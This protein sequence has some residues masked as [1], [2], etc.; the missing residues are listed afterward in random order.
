MTD[1]PATDDRATDNWAAN[2]LPT[3]GPG[4]P[5]A[6]PEWARLQRDLLSAA[7][8]AAVTFVDRYTR[9]DGTLP[10]RESWIG[11]DGSDDPYEAFQG[12]PMLYLLGGSERLLEIAHREWAAV[13]E[14]WTAYGQIYREYDGHYDWMHHG[15]ADNLLRLLGM[16]DP[17]NAEHRERVARFAGFYT[18]EDPLAPNYDPSKRLIRSPLTGSRGPRFTVTGEDWETHREVLDAYPPPFEDI[19]GVDGPTCQWTDDAIFAEILERM[20]ARMTHGDV[21][22]NLTA[23]SLLS[24]AYLLTGEDKYRQWVLGYHDAWQERTRRNNGLI[25]D[26]VG[27]TDRIG[28]NLDG[29]WWGGYYGWRWPHG[30]AQLLEAVSVASCNAALLSGDTG[31]LDL[32]RAQLDHL[33]DLGH[34]EDGGWVVPHRHVDAG[35]T[36]YRRPDPKI[37]VMCWSLTHDDADSERVRRLSDSQTWGTPT[38][39]RTKANGAGNSEHWFAYVNGA[40]PDYPTQ[41][42]RIN[43]EQLVRRLEEIRDDNGNPADWDIH[44]WQNMSPL[45]LEGL[46]QLTL[47]APMHLYHGGL[48]H[49]AVRYFDAVAKRPGLPPG[50]AA[51]VERVTSS[52]TSLQLVNCSDTGAREV[53]VQAGGF[54]EHRVEHVTDL[55]AVG[56]KPMPVGGSAFRVHLE[57]RST[58]RLELAVQRFAY[59]PSYRSATG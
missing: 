41:I 23:T 5:S 59:R 58:L 51:L 22:Q 30:A 39:R 2:D 57:P 19:P 48:Q 32:I 28:E 49:A 24:H 43:H 37:P 35:W 20:N 27:L 53:I 3:V 45:Y 54:A 21:P 10:W 55:D 6:P 38:A 12:L 50:V 18:G 42:L 7:E 16:A 9:P 13:T 25:P 15:E 14:Q 26:N 56:S 47:G 11:L 17:A 29:K 1:D 34:E 46:V 52:T 40:N 8:Q 36:A 31:R 4:T 44:H 33:W